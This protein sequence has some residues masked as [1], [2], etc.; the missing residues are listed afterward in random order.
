MGPINF[1][2]VHVK[3]RATKENNEEPSQ[4]EMFIATRTKT[5]KEI[6]VDTQI[7]ITE[8]QNRRNSRETADDA[9]RE[10]FG[11]E[12]PGRLRCYGR[13]MITSSLKEEEE[14]NRLKQKHANEI[15]SL[16][17][18]MNEKMN[19]MRVECDI[20]LASCCKITMDLNVQDIQG[21]VGSN[22]VSPIFDASSA[23]AVRGKNI[24]HSS[25]STHDSIIQKGNGGDQI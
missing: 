5:G 3:L 25:G 14:I 23:Q 6:Q 13:S 9:F 4:P 7:A 21:V 2:R 16:K 1:A 11:K 22:I 17:E 12:Q 24:A 8:L 15:S 19:E 10:V 18:E 20:F